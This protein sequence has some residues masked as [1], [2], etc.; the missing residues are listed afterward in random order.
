ML[1]LL[2]LLVW[3]THT[4]VSLDIDTD[5]NL[6]SDLKGCLI[7]NPSAVKSC[8]NKDGIPVDITESSLL[9]KGNTCIFEHEEYP[10]VCQ[11]GMIT[12]TAGG[13]FVEERTVKRKKRFFIGELVLGIAC[14]FLCGGSHQHSTPNSPPMI[15]KNAALKVSTPIFAPQRKSSARVY[16]D[17]PVITDPEQGTLRITTSPSNF[18]SGGE[19]TEGSYVIHFIGTDGGGLSAYDY[20]MFEVKV[21]RCGPLRRPENGDINCDNGDMIYGTTCTVS[22]KSGFYVSGTSNMLCQKN[23]Y[24]SPGSTPNCKPKTCRGLPNISNGRISCYNNKMVFDNV[25]EVVCDE[26]FRAIGNHLIRCNSE[27]QWGALPTCKDILPPTFLRGECPDD[28]QVYIDST[29][30]TA[31][32]TWEVPTGTDNSKERVIIKE[33]HGYVPG[34]RFSAGSYVVKY[35]IEDQ[36]HNKGDY[37]NFRIEVLT[38]SCEPPNLLVPHLVYEC[39]DSYRLGASC[40]LRCKS[41][42]PLGGANQIHCQVKKQVLIHQRGYNLIINMYHYYHFVETNCSRAALGEPL[43]GALACSEWTHGQMCQMQCES[44]Y[45]IPYIGLGFFVCGR[46]DGKWRPTNNVPD[47]DVKMVVTHIHLPGKFYYYTGHCNSSAENM[48]QIK[49]NFVQALNT[50]M[51]SEACRGVPGCR[52]EN[53]NVT[54]GPISGR[55]RRDVSTNMFFTSI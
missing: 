14:I 34:Q 30:N 42:Y 39:P 51:F 19:Y 32:I 15:T 35:S 21:Y 27:G 9:Q 37:C 3:S 5:I 20:L 28:M 55:H 31:T 7:A 13:K 46:S 24:W 11:N 17:D 29:N 25:C 38:I 1:P 8:R 10:V 45:D 50:S 18:R 12:L 54:C 33:E 41:G 53:V 6:S 43:N 23:G 40:S 52:A 2:Y 22:C 36:E 4:V 49:V 47:C 16:W 44:G 26:G 48:R